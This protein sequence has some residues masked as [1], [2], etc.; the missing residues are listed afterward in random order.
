[1]K[2]STCT[3]RCLIVCS[4][5]SILISYD[6]GKMMKRQASV[7][8]KRG[9]TELT[10]RLMNEIANS[11]EVFRPSASLYALSRLND[12]NDSVTSSPSTKPP[13]EID[14][15]VSGGGLKGYYACGALYVLQVHLL[16]Q[17]M[18]ITR[19]SGSS[20]GAWS[21]LF[22]CT[23]LSFEWWV[24]SYHLCAKYPHKTLLE[25]FEELLVG[26]IFVLILLIV[27]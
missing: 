22:I 17:N 15:V 26:Y 11:V 19:I 18:R 12:E 27:I 21:A 20:A 24:E 3:N 4:I 16:N 8:I 23:G 10:L 6:L 1:M 2:S 25:A 5:Y 7:V 9:S 14:L 13:V